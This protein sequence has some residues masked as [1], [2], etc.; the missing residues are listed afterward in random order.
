[1][2]EPHVSIFRE[3]RRCCPALASWPGATPAYAARRGAVSH[4]ARA[5]PL[6]ATI[7]T[8]SASLAL[9]RPA[10]AS[11]KAPKVVCSSQSGTT[12]LPVLWLPGPAAA[13]DATAPRALP[14]RERRKTRG[15][16]R[17]AAV[18]GEDAW[19][20]HVECGSERRTG[21]ARHG[22]DTFLWT[23]LPTG[24]TM[25]GNSHGRLR[26]CAPSHRG[27]RS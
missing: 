9:Q 23:I 17:T 25:T 20:P 16:S 3:R 19:P 24:V 14:V 13:C 18:S 6:S 21:C 7:T 11:K 8:V 22:R 10:A 1:M 12:C 5:M 2:T 15:V 27:E 4:R 26:R